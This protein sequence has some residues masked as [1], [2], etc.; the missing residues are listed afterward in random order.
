MDSLR[1]RIQN[2]LDA[3]D[4]SYS[5][6]DLVDMIQGEIFKELGNL[7]DEIIIPLDEMEAG[8]LQAGL[9]KSK[10]EQKYITDSVLDYV[11]DQSLKDYY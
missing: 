9:Q 6:D 4:G 7:V 1:R 2:I 5:K 3:D 8:Q 11:N 10:S